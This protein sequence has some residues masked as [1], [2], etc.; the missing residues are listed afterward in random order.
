[1]VDNARNLKTS[2]KCIQEL[3]LHKLAVDRVRE[4]NINE[5]LKHLKE[6]KKN[7]VIRT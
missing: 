2:A 6:T 3:S 1:M 4:R 5:E 7:F